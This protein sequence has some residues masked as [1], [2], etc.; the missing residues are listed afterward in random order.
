M[1]AGMINPVEAFEHGFAK[2]M[3]VNPNEVVAVSSG[4]A[5]LHIACLLSRVKGRHVIT[6]PF[7]FPA[8]VNAIIIA[9]GKPLFIDVGLDCLLNPDLVWR[10]ISSESYDVAALLPVHLFGRVFN[11]NKVISQTKEKNIRIIE[12]ASQALGAKHGDAYAGTV[13]DFGTFSFYASKNLPTFE[14][15]MLL[16][17]EE[18]NAAEARSL[19]NHGFKDGDMVSLGYNNKISWLSAFLGQQYLAL[20]KTAIMAELGIYGMA[21]GYYPKTVYQHTW[22]RDN[23]DKWEIYQECPIAESLAAQVRGHRK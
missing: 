5:A 2:F 17:R 3:N 19:R 18:G 4:S 9:G 15:G 16:C 8:T 22:Y 7:T 12:D 10:C 21:D 20:H 14:G 6:T 11:I 23:P 13:G 1:M